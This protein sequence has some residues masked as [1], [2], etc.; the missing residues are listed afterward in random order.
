[1]ESL[2]RLLPGPQPSYVRYPVT[3][4][5]VL[6][7]FAFRLSM[8]EGTGRFGFIHFILPI[9]ASSLLFNRGT[10]YFAVGLSAAL[11]A[12]V[13]PWPNKYEANFAALAVFIFVGVCLVFVSEGL[14]TALV[15]A[16]DA[17]R[18]SDALLLEMSHRVKNKFSMIN[19]IISLQARNA[20][21]QV[22]RALEDVS[23]RVQVIATVHNYLQLSRQ[24]G[25][26]DMAA[27]LPGLTEALRD[28][29]C[30]PRPI[31]VSAKSDSV[32][33]PP[34][35]A[36]SVGLIVNELVT[37]A[38]KYAFDDT[39]SGRIVVELRRTDDQLRLT[40][41]DNGKGGAKDE[42]AGLGT[43]L[44]SVFAGQ[45]GGSAAWEDRPEGG[46]QA[47]IIFPA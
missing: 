25:S 30:G 17:Q 47:N 27:Y 13:L 46:C 42:V 4:L 24:Q 39:R 45:L 18:A 35:R 33:L 12:I 29:L 28:A 3:A 36:L 23:S 6:L 9:I 10:G 16:H 8:G 44:V 5:I 41:T 2:F 31:V 1:M 43:R 26:I 11:I 34:E 21:P 19:S 7:G 32:H 14:H 20:E 15:K 38:F 22:K 37:N 40:V